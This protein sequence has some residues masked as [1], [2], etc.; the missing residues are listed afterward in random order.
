MRTRKFWL[1]EREEGAFRQRAAETRNGH[2]LKRL[3]AVRWD[4]KGS[5]LEPITDRIGR[6]ERRMLGWVSDYQRDGLS[7]LKP[8]WD[9]Q[10]ANK[11]R[12]A[13][14]A[15]ITRKVE[16]YRPDQGLPSEGRLSQGECWTVSDRQVAVKRW[17]G[18]AYTGADSYRTVFYEAGLSYQRTDGV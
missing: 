11:L 12:A 13:A 7:G 17:V 6:S 5:S 14:R 4:G 8:G 2:E 15:A 9:G 10:N 1:N 16:Q 18:V 3:Q